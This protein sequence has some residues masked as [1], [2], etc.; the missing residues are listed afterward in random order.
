MASIILLAGVAIYFSVEK[1]HERNEKKRELMALQNVLHGPAEELW[2]DEDVKTIVDDELATVDG[3]KGLASHP[4]LDQHP[5]I[6]DGKKKSR[7]L[8]RFRL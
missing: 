8:F 7:R 6:R 4:A 1:I 5:A 2:H 3:R